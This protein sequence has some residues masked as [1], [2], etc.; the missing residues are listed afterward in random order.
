MFHN[1]EIKKAKEEKAKQQEEEKLQTFEEHCKEYDRE[2]CFSP[3]K[4]FDVKPSNVI[5][6]SAKSVFEQYGFAHQT[7]SFEFD[8]AFVTVD[9]NISRNLSRCEDETQRPY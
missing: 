2:H 5:Y 8:N 3:G 6:E 9:I 7:T 4:L 1:L